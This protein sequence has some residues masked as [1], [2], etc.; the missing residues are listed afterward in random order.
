MVTN[1]SML[2][3]L[4][5]RPAQINRL[6]LALMDEIDHAQKEL[7][8]R[9]RDAVDKDRVYR[10]MFASELLKLKSVEGTVQDKKAAAD[11]ACDET[12]FFAKLSEGLRESALEAVRNARSKLSALQSIGANVRIE[13]ELTRT[14]TP[15]F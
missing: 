3:D 6:L 8:M 4:Y 12:R 11:G 14:P 5:L 1:L 10:A 9:T 13:E 15:E 7:V 2:E